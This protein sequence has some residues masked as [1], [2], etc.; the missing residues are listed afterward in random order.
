MNNY[1]IEVNTSGQ[2]S[3]S[4]RRT[5][6]SDGLIQDEIDYI[7]INVFENTL[8]G[9]TPENLKTIL[10]IDTGNSSWLVNPN[11]ANEI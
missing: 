10:N 1:K 3:S 8:T 2:I 4:R 11:D 7:G 5:D 9:T 6:I